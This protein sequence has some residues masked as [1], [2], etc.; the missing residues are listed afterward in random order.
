VRCMQM[1]KFAARY[2]SHE[3][4]HNAERKLDPD[5]RC[6]SYLGLLRAEEYREKCGHAIDI[7]MEGLK[8]EFV[9]IGACGTQSHYYYWDFISEKLKEYPCGTTP[10]HNFP[11]RLYADRTSELST[12]VPVHE[13]KYCDEE[14]V[15]SALSARIEEVLSKVELDL[16]W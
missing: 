12:E 4:V 8:N 6:F 5:Y 3:V 7:A 14:A 15:R 13:C 10:L 9:H 16:E 2:L 1:A 11:L